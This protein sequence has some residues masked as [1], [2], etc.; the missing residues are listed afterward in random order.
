MNWLA[1]VCALAACDQVFG[2]RSTHALDAQYFD[3]PSDAPYSCPPIGTTPT[4]TA[5]LREQL[6]QACASYTVATV[7]RAMAQCPEAS[8]VYYGPAG[9]P[10]AKAVIV[11]DV[12]TQEVEFMRIAPEGDHAIASLFDLTAEMYY[13]EQFQ[14]MPDN[15]WHDVHLVLALPFGGIVSYPLIS[16]PSRE[17]GAHVLVIQYNL[18]P[19]PSTL[20]E[21]V[22]DANP[23][24]GQPWHQQL[25]KVFDPATFSIVNGM[26]MT[27]DGLRNV[28]FMQAVVPAGAYYQDRATLGDAFSTP[29]LLS[30]VPETSGTDP[31]MTEDCSRVYVSG[32]GAVFYVTQ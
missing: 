16:T 19:T 15:A 13:I 27:P 14:L 3:A 20:Y 25:A 29:A 2:L 18:Y 6:P 17:P 26:S 22:D 10:L 4:F 24:P 31:F 9:G 12:A 32:L 8:S 5:S 30:N 7:D 1:L 28:F 21:M 23:D 11:L